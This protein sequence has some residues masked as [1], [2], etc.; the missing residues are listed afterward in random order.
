MDWKIDGIAGKEADVMG[1]NM[2]HTQQQ[3]PPPMEFS[4]SPN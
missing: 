2:E 3:A 1:T 4:G